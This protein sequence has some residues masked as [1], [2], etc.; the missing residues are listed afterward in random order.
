MS[1]TPHTRK[2]LRVAGLLGGMVIGMVGLSFAAV[3]LYDLFCRVTGY[4]GT[5]RTAEA[6]SERTSDLMVTVRFDANVAAGVPWSFRPEVREVRVRAGESATI[7]YIAEN[8]ADRTTRGTATY[9]VS[10]NGAGPYFYKVQCFCFTEQALEPGERVEMPVQFYVDPDMELDTEVR[11]VRTITLSYTFFP[12]RGDGQPVADA[13][14]D[15]PG[16]KM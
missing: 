2:N 6:A 10:P 4:G 3:P 14:G 7:N 16:E 13:G 15:V 11:N 5:T 12:L 9:N 1:S 8:L